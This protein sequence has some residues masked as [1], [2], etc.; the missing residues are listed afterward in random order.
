M[1][2]CELCIYLVLLADWSAL[3]SWEG[4]QPLL[5]AAAVA[6]VPVL[7]SRRIVDFGKKAC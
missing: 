4:R 3:D 1:Q 5:L 2:V 6:A 7:Y